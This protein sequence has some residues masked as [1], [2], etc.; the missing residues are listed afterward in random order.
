MQPLQLGFPGK[1]LLTGGYCILHPQF[2]GLVLTTSNKF[3]ATVTRNSNSGDSIVIWSKLYNKEYVIDSNNCNTCHP[4]IDAAFKVIY[5]LYPDIELC[6]GRID[7]MGSDLFIK[8]TTKTGLGS[9]AAFTACIVTGIAYIQRLELPHHVLHNICQLVHFIG[10]NK[11][12]SGFDVAAMFYGSGIFSN[13]LS[14][15]RRLATEIMCCTEAVNANEIISTE[16]SPISCFDSP[17]PFSVYLLDVKDGPTHTDTRI[18]VRAFKEFMTAEH[19]ECMCLLSEINQNNQN[20]VEAIK[21]QCVTSLHS[22]AI[23]D[24]YRRLG[25]R[26]NLPIIPE[27]RRSLLNSIEN[28]DSIP[29]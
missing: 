17:F 2:S 21:A 20:F 18:N 8:G 29:T 26:I 9:S 5:L 6:G 15:L 22:L 13:T 24:A 3:E 1:I 16:Y 25:E 11:V 4:F 27:D 12:G 23:R 19:D 14:Q 7:V 10:Q 28:H